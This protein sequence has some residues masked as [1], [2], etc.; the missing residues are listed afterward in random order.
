V[1][2][3]PLR[4]S[5]AGGA[6]MLYLALALI[7]LAPLLPRFGDAILGGP[8]ANVDGWQHTWHLWWAAQ[9]LT[10][11]QN[12]FFTPL[13]F[14]PQGASLYVQPLNLSNGLL[15]LPITL[16]FG[17][18]A[19][20][21][22]AALLSFV[23]AGLAGYLL[24]LRVS[25]QPLAAL[26]GGLVLAWAPF[27]LTRLYDGQLELLGVQWPAFYAFFALRALER[28]R[29]GDAL[30]A[31]ALLALT[32]YTS[33]YYLLFMLVWSAA[34][35]LLWLRRPWLSAVRQWALI[36]AT[37]LALLAPALVPGLAGLYGAERSL[38]AVEPQEL[39]TYSANLLDFVLPS[40][41]H[42]LWGERVFQAV[43]ATW[44][45]L[46][47]DWNV[48]LGYS[49][50][51]LAALG[52]ALAW[53]TAWR[54][55]L[56][57]G[58]GILFALGPELQLGPWRS[59]IPLPYRLLQELPGADFARR[60]LHFTLLTTLALAPLAALGT[61]EL[62]ARAGGSRRL[63]ALALVAALGF[64]LLPARWMLHDAR[65]H[66][67]YAT[68]GPD[69]GALLHVPLPL[70]KDVE[71]Q[72]AQ[73]SHGAPIIGGYL[74]RIPR[75]DLPYA[76][77]V[78]PLWQLRA[79]TGSLLAPLE[80]A[81]SALSHY[82]IRQVIVSW[83]QIDPDRH[84]LVEQALAQVLPGVA[85]TYT[86]ATLSAYRVPAVPRP[87]PFAYFGAGWYD[88]EQSELRRW[89]WMGAQGDLLLVNP[90][91]GPQP[92]ELSLTL[93]SY[94]QPRELD[95]SLGGAA[96]GRWNVPA[97]PA[98][99][100]RRLHLLL[101]PGDWRLSLAAPAVTEA[102]PEGRRLSIVLTEADLRFTSLIR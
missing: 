5:D 1:S 8:I 68:L 38:A 69:D 26:V 4:L 6:L 82:Q 73:L 86:D 94:Q 46:S 80:A 89:R 21:N 83:D 19:G 87:E 39:R 33:W 10:S 25:G 57:A 49:V 44:H 15:M 22:T 32:G 51:L 47:G 42:P 34:F 100:T 71:A 74:A 43:G 53:P 48:A 41:L 23:L 55:G 95:L 24:A 92:A 56:L 67:Y 16:G 35:A 27:H 61:R 101:P 65:T 98:R 2:G 7:G 93:E 63:A 85:P 54:W 13:L 20:Y 97:Q 81:P 29:V 31:G 102:A 12:P 18:V 62:L 58:L 52:C 90:G 79:E 3:R 50:L 14:H 99:L 66:P 45:P 84:A 11:G 36:G 64:E 91:D 28:R 70:Y 78:R 59:G 77:G 76:P 30:A 60:P 96:L 9:A 40:Y 88:E 75:Y 37:G 72:K 17:P